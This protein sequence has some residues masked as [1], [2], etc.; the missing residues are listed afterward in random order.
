MKQAEGL[1]GNGGQAALLSLE[2]LVHLGHFQEPGNLS[3]VKE[4]V[5]RQANRLP[6]CPGGEQA[7]RPFFP[8]EAQ[9]SVDT[10]HEAEDPGGVLGQNSQPQRQGKQQYAGG[11]VLLD[12]RLQQIKTSGEEEEQERVL[13]EFRAQRDQSRSKAEEDQTDEGGSLVGDP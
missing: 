12:S 1:A 7:R 11:G 13:A 10:H 5:N 4:A 2:H 6:A 9:Q 8:G 3:L